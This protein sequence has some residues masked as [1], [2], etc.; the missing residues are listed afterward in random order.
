MLIKYKNRQRLYCYA[1]DIILVEDFV[2]YLYNF[3][4]SIRDQD[5]NDIINKN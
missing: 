2:W 4:S 1:I 5:D 3:I